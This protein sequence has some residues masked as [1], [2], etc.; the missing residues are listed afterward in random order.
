[1]KLVVASLKQYSWLPITGEFC[2]KSHKINHFLIIFSNLHDH[3]T[4]TQAIDWRL[5]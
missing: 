5:L 4:L 1:L 3:P 2:G